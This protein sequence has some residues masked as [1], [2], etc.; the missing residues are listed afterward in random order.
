MYQYENKII[1]KNGGFIA[2]SAM[3]T[4]NKPPRHNPLRTTAKL[5]PM[6]RKILL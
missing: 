6:I 2:Y 3:K 1:Q 4:P 5:S